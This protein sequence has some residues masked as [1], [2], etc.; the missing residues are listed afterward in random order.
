MNRGFTVTYAIPRG[1]GRFHQ[2]QSPPPRRTPDGQ[3]QR[4]NGCSGVVP[5]LRPRTTSSISD[6]TRVKISSWRQHPQTRGCVAR[7]IGRLPTYPGCID[8][9]PLTPDEFGKCQEPL[10]SLRRIIAV[11]SFVQRRRSLLPRSVSSFI[12]SFS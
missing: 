2:L 11:S 6:A 1:L 5:I 8:T 10:P 12:L 7:Q 3:P 4:K 9:K